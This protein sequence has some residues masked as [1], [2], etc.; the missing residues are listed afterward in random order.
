LGAFLYQSQ[1]FLF[2]LFNG[3]YSPIE[4]PPGKRREF[5]LNHPFDKLR[6]GLSQLADSGVK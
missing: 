1:D 6:T 2:Q 3:W 5:N 4:T